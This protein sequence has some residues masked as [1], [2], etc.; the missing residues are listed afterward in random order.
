MLAN[1]RSRA[2]VL[3]RKCACGGLTPGGEC[4][5]C[6][7]KREALLRPSTNGPGSADAVP[8][9]VGEVLRSRG[10][11][12][13]RPTQAF[14]EQRF[15]SDFSS[16]RVHTDSKAAEST[17]AVSA[18]AY[19]AGR[20]VVFDANQYAPYTSDGRHLIA[21]EL[22]HV[23]QQGSIDNFQPQ[24]IGDANNAAEREASQA[25]DETIGARAKTV[26]AR[27]SPRSPAALQR[28]PAR[29]VSC[30]THLPLTLPDGTTIDDPVAVITAAENEANLLLDNAIAELSFTID[31]IGGGAPIAFPTIS[32]ALALGLQLMGLDPDSERVWTQHGGVG[33]FT[34]AL[35]LRRLRFIRGPIGKGDFFFVCLGPPAG[36]ISDCS[37]PIC[38]GAE[39]ASC[40]GSFITNFCEPFWRGSDADQAA[41]IIHETSHN[42]AEFIG[43]AG[44][45]GRGE[46]IAE[47]Y[48]R[49]AQVIGGVD[50]GEQRLDLCPD[51]T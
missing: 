44:E 4:A 18:L 21:H 34:A 29:K 1:E 11:P 10:Q 19:T 47:C 46:N 33:N 30:A 5:A 2:G 15:G 20:H 32:D 45:I 12:L 40:A 8:P 39:A 35:L 23:V 3:Q 14:M 48:V 42:F 6:A 31:Q 36:T 51:P 13:D 38:Q 27:V 43:S 49:F 22:A 37:G 26:I 7:G 28:T 41:T 17:R 25:A 9:I 24:R 16:V 50:I